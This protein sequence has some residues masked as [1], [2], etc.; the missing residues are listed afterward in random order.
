MAVEFVSTDKGVRSFALGKVFVNF[1]LNANS[2]SLPE[3]RAAWTKLAEESS[4]WTVDV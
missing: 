1:Y 4:S 3:H 2:P